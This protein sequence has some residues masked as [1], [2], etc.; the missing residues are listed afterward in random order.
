MVESES[1]VS[2]IANDAVKSLLYEVS[3]NPKPGLVDPV[4]PGPHP[5]MDIFT[6]IDSSMSLKDYFLKAA[7]L[8]YSYQGQLSKMF[9]ELREYGKTAE[10]AM[11]EATSQVNTHKGAI[12]SLGIMTCA[13]AYSEQR[14]MAVQDVIKQ[15]LLGLTKHDFA[16]LTE[17]NPENLTAGEIQYLRFGYKGIRGE[18]EDGFP[19]VFRVAFP[20]LCRATGTKNQRLIDTL[21][22]LVSINEDSNLVKRADNDLNII[23]WARTEAIDVLNSGGSKTKLGMQKL[24]EMNQKFLGRNLSLGGTADLLILTIFIGLRNK[25]L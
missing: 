8:G 19:K 16:N 14:H 2:E 12:F 3:V 20:F 22:K 6:F 1:V 15:M 21:L 5:D 11:F 13:M 10:K 4:S 18:A 24:Y 9:L 17:K 25:A 7:D 23:N